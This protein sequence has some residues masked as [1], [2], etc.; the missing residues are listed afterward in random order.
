MEEDVKNI[1]NTGLN[2]TQMGQYFETSTDT[3][4][5]TWCMSWR[6]IVPQGLLH[7]CLAFCLNIVFQFL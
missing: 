2:R 3:R 5:E 7:I 1:R 4:E 6:R